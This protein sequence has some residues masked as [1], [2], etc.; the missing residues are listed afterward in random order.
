MSQKKK[1]VTGLYQKLP[2]TVGKYRVPVQHDPKGLFTGP[3]TASWM[4][5][6]TCG[7]ETASL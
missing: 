7:V 1:V 6:E 3:V 5:S 2:S 4:S